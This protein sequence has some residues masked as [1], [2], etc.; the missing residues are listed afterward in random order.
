MQAAALAA[1]DLCCRRGDRWLFHGLSLTLARGDALHIRGPNGFGKSS[2]IRMLAGLL[3]PS[4]SPQTG[5]VGR[6]EWT[7][8]VAL[9]DERHGLDAALPL[10]QALAFWAR[11]DAPLPDGTLER[12]G[13]TR[14]LDVPVRYLSTGQ[15]KRAAL[16][17][18]IG[19]HAPHW[20]LDEPLN[21]LDTAACAQVETLIAQHRAQGG[22]AVVISHQPIAL[23]GARAID[24]GRPP[25]PSEVAP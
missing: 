6:V 23:P 2:L 12:L 3:P 20:L 21:G 18:V 1:T 22:T 10:G 14:L 4:P 25:R 13:L 19:Q 16:A 8:P 7:G 5:L 24:L 11:I 15:K 9:I 17:R